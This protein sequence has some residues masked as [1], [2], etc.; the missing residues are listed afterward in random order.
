MKRTI[1]GYVS[2]D[3]RI[4]KPNLGS[5]SLIV[6]NFFSTYKPIR[7]SLQAFTSLG[8]IVSK[9]KVLYSKIDPANTIIEK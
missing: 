6:W 9:N 4:C 5:R 8:C 3:Y 7:R 2:D 1:D